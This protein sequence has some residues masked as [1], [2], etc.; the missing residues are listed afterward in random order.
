MIK[1]SLVIETSPKG[2]TLTR[3]Y[4][5]SKNITSDERDVLAGE[6][7]KSDFKNF[8]HS[9][10]EVAKKIVLSSENRGG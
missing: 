7:K 2:I 4:D 5:E 3:L 6:I 10:G 8:A 1:I 9:L